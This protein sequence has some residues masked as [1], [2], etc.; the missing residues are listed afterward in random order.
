MMPTNLSSGKFDKPKAVNF[1]DGNYIFI[2]YSHRNSS[3]VWGDLSILSSCEL[4]FWYDDA[5]V[6]G[7]DWKERAWQAMSHPNCVGVLFVVTKASLKSKAIFEELNMATRISASRDNFGIFCMNVGAKSV[8]QMVADC[9]VEEPVASLY[10]AVFPEDD[11]FIARSSRKQ[12]TEHVPYLLELFD[13]LGLVKPKYKNMVERSPFTLEQ[14]KNGYAI[15]AYKGKSAQIIIPQKV[16]NKRVV[17]IGP[18]AFQNMTFIKKVQMVGDIF[19]VFDNAFDGCTNLKQVE[20]SGALQYVGHECFKGCKSLKKVVFN[21]NLQS[22]GDYSFYECRGLCE[23]DFANA[24]VSVGYSAFSQCVNLDKISLSPNTVAIDDYA[25]GGTAIKSVDLYDKIE[26]LGEHCFTCNPNLKVI[27]FVGTKLPAKLPQKLVSLCPQFQHFVLPFCMDEQNKKVLQGYGNVVSRLDK[28]TALSNDGNGFVWESIN[29]ADSYVVTVGEESFSTTQ[30]YLPFAFKR[31][32]YRVSICAHSN[33]NNVNDAISHF[34]Y[35]VKLPQIQN[36]VLMGGDFFE[37][38]VHLDS[39]VHTIAD[40]AFQNNLSVTSLCFGGS[41][42]GNSAFEMASNLENV[43]FEN[44]VTVGDGAFRSCTK[45]HTVDMHKITALSQGAF[46][47]CY[48]LDNIRFDDS[49]NVLPTKCFRRCINLQN[50]SLPKNLVEMQSECLRGCMSIRS[51]TIP[52]G[53]ATIGERALTYLVIKKIVLPSALQNFHQSNLQN[54]SYLEQIMIENNSQFSISADGALMKNGD[55]L[56]RFP[57]AKH[58]KALC[59]DKNV[60]VV[61]AGAFQDSSYIQTF[62]ATNVEHICDNAFYGC[63]ALTCVHLPATLKSIGANAFVHC[64]K[65]Q[66]VYIHGDDYVQIAPNSFGDKV[67]VVV[68]A[69]KAQKLVT[70]EWKK[71]KEVVVDEF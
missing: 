31:K 71:V 48:R 22:I 63:A 37:G 38:K 27:N 56:L 30:N 46:E 14:Y 19:D 12:S 40:G 33:Q 67:K 68:S 10:R 54:C 7:K 17:A 35:Q 24:H 11:I 58:T 13:E 61:Q 64:E 8:S 29:G 70:A 53:V 50:F 20:F 21:N 23:V 1:A 5:M 45:L 42:V 25:F 15:T 60:K 36:G 51:L 69:K 3:L 49:L 6:V 57:P 62:D 52:N 39:Q 44:G 59:L 47:C 2:S 16:G 9:D 55:T 28:V 32:K 18:K 66:T 26:S 65:L 43:H 41:H 4:P 34:V